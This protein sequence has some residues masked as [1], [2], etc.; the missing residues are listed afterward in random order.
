MK[1]LHSH[2]YV[3]IS[4]R[5]KVHLLEKVT[6]LSFGQKIVRLLRISYVHYCGHKT[7]PMVPILTHINPAHTLQLY[8]PKICFN[9]ILTSVPILY[10]DLFSSGFETKYLYPF[11]ISHMRATCSAHLTLLYF[12]IVIVFGTEYKFSIL[13]SPH[14]LCWVYSYLIKYFGPR[15]ARTDK[16]KLIVP[17]RCRR[18]SN[19]FPRD[20][21][22]RIIRM[23]I[24]HW[25]QPKH[26][27]IVQYLFRHM[28]S[29]IF[30]LILCHHQINLFC[31]FF[32]ERNCFRLWKRFKLIWNNCFYKA[33]RRW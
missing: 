14:L 13:L 24:T 28:P 11:I 30:V 6:V 17:V 4:P 7:P 19:V 15:Y 27:S 22:V 1:T 25:K 12:D 31:D 3:W 5:S 20:R 26:N 33:R 21:G 8:F 23:H 10:S 18:F 29:V 16:T 32:V 9:I 2:W